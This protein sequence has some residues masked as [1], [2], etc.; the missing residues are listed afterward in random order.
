[1]QNIGEVVGWKFNHTPGIMTRNKKIT[2]WPESLG[3]IPSD[4]QIA[5]WAVEYEEIEAEAELIKTKFHLV[6][7]DR[8]RTE[9]VKQLKFEGKVL[10]HFDNNGNRI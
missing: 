6:A 10:K 8:D 4:A 2:Q 5:T 3:P 7:E 9:A 1:M